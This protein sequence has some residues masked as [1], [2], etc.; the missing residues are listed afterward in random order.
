MTQT[1]LTLPVSGMTCANCAMNIERNV[2]KLAGVDAVQVNFASEQAGV[3]FDDQQ[4]KLD[5]IVAK[6]KQVGFSVVRAEIDFAVTG[7]TCAN[8]AAN[9]ERALKKKVPGVMQASVNLATE[10]VFVTYIPGITS[11]E[12]IYA[13]VE[14]P[15]G[16]FGCY[17]VSDGAN[18][19]YRL[20]VRA[21]GF[22]HLSAM[23]EMTRGHM[24][25]DVV[26]VIGT[27]DIV[28]GEI[29]R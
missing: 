23:D 7:M 4:I 3:R 9:I 5:D 12:D 25:A 14:A 27:M 22:V 8:C 17:I 1:N 11:L 16:E 10:R 24:L 20:K 19:P 15:K 18:K 6:I 13:A 29:D 28:F 21:P 2:G 26:A